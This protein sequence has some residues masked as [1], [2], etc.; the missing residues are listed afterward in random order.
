MSKFLS[1]LLAAAFAA[2]TI[3]P[4]M[5]A[6]EMAKE[7]KEVKHEKKAKHE[8][9]EKHAKKAKHEKKEEMKK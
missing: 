8:K 1:I 5:A 9:K 7:K 2:V 3:T 4:V 6:E